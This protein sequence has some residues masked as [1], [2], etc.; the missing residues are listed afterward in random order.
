MSRIINNVDSINLDGL[1]QRFSLTIE[2]I[3]QGVGFR[4]YIYRLAQELGLKGWVSN[5]LEG[6]LVDI[7]GE[8]L[9]L[10][11]F[12]FRLEKEKP[13]NAEITTIHLETLS[14]KNH[15]DFKI[16]NSNNTG[17]KQTA[18]IPDIATCLECLQ[19]ILDIKDRRYQYP[20]TNCINCGPRFSII[21]NL[22]YDRCNTSMKN[23]L[24]C[25]ECQT[26][27]NLPTTRR[28]HAQPNACSNCGP[29]LEFWDNKGKVLAT[30]A[31]AL[32]L[33]IKFI[34]QGKII[35]VKNT[36]GFHLI[37][38]AFNETT[39]SQLRQRK[40]RDEKPFALLY[41]S[42]ELVKEHT[43]ISSLENKILS[44]AISPIVLLKRREDKKLFD[45]VAPENPYLGIMLANNPLQHLMMKALAMPVIAT[46]GNI[47]EEP[48]CID[49]YEA[50]E[51][52]NSLADGFL[53]HNRPITQPID[54]S[55][56]QVVL[57]REMVIRRAR[58]YGSL[59]LEIESV[60]PGI[61]A[62][63]G[64]LKNT[65][66]MSTTSGIYLSQHIGN[67]QTEKTFNIFE[68]TLDK[69]KNI[70]QSQVFTIA[71]DLHSEYL[72][73]K[74]A[75]KHASK[76]LTTVAVQHHYAHIL[77]CM[78]ENKLEVD[79]LGVVW[80]G[81]GYGLN[82]TIWGGEFLQIINK[83]FSRIGHLK[84][85]PLIGSEK[86]V[87]EPRRIALGLVYEAFGEECFEYNLPF[88][89]SFTK[90]ELNILKQ[91]LRNKLN[92][93]F[94]SSI[95]RLF[96]G[97]ASILGI[98]HYNNFE[99]QAAI[100]LEFSLSNT[101]IE[102]SYNFVIDE[103]HPLIIDWQDLLKE[104]LSDLEKNI[105]I[106]IISAKFHNALA[107]LVVEIAKRVAQEKV[108]LTGGCFQNRY[109]LEKTVLSLKAAGFSP[110]W[111]QRVP[112]NDGGI[113]LG[114]IFAAIRQM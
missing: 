88:I 94:T 49:E 104:I 103:K 11:K 61:L 83:G 65:V 25:E 53:V 78:A 114:Q 24:M 41:P 42:L 39:I 106:A 84:E 99:A 18:I 76:Q 66:A 64:H 37:A 23:F 89:N 51:R 43:I 108:V 5:N 57:E 13:L 105:P 60:K 55:V 7:E 71:H 47:S 54:D 14:I 36:G 86:A 97:V 22:P 68:N 19:E 45:K 28:F 52:L 10:E 62:V 15:Q 95:G 101:K 50:L 8:K 73:T 80:D 40:H 38:N 6:V 56:V 12:L 69:I 72:S 48:I 109:L 20:F 33:A 96:D 112:T 70:Y 34:K 17:S 4:P 74:Y 91:M 100:K 59:L 63:G 31:D 46:S 93:P 58:G 9:Q 27:Y 82:N 16:I 29:S 44:S 75:V 26:E 21:E 111:H 30:K 85:F 3:V 79:L 77:S 87:K 32:Q 107:N 1:S 92:T 102:E 113:S 35:A 90:Q 81:S 2:G 67:L 98:Q 110:Y